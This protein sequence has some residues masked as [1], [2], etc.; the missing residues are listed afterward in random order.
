MK[1]AVDEV[2]PHT[3]SWQNWSIYMSSLF[4]REYV[5]TICL[6]LLTSRLGGDIFIVGPIVTLYVNIVFRR[7]LNNPFVLTLACTSAG[8]WRKANVSGFPGFDFKK[9]SSIHLF[10]F[11]VLILIAQLS[12]AASAAGIRVYNEK[13]LGH[14]F[15]K[16]AAWGTGQMHLRADVTT[17]T[18]CWK[19]S[20][21]PWDATS[22]EIPIRLLGNMTSEHI[23]DGACTARIQWRWWFMEE[24]GAVLFLIVA[25]IH[26]WKWLRWK[27]ATKGNPNEQSEQYCE[28]III[29]STASASLGLMTTM[30]F[31]TASAGMHTS[32]F[33]GVYQALG[34]EEARTNLDEHWVRA[35]GGCVGCMMAVFYEWGMAWASGYKNGENSFAD[36]I[37]KLL[38]IAEI[39]PEK[40]ADD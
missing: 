3:I 30:A 32:M 33:L 31:P 17:D 13:V 10:L 34:P 26:V 35:F 24:V 4:I 6:L 20:A 12:G 15:I 38:Y 7:P 11:F 27:D 9:T 28:N 19:Q 39:P 14:E 16:G 36:T 1:P 22:V 8:D 37:H 25:Y 18:T 29:F 2:T 23:R 5:S 21:F 40:K